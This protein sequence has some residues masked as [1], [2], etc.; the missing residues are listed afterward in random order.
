MLGFGNSIAFSLAVFGSVGV[1]LDLVCAIPFIRRESLVGGALAGAVA[2]LTKFGVVKVIA[3]AAGG[4]KHVAFVGLAVATLNHILFGIVGGL[5][6]VMIFHKSR[7]IARKR[8]S[9]T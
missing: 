9:S 2:H 7:S 8:R 1:A 3:V 6:A 4:L 5:I